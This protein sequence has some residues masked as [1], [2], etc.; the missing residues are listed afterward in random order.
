MAVVRERLWS[1]R[2]AAWRDIRLPA[3]LRRIGPSI[4]VS[5]FTVDGAIHCGWERDGGELVAL[6]GRRTWSAGECS[7]RSS[8]TQVR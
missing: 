2:V 8:I 5:G 1:R 7:R 3:R 4:P 6:A